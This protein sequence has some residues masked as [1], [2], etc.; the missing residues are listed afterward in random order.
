MESVT[1]LAELFPSTAPSS[2]GTNNANELGQEDFL[3]LMVAQLKNQDP[4]NPQDNSEF[5]AQIAQFGTVSG[6]QDLADKFDGL[7]ATLYSSQALEA[8]GVVGREVVTDSNLGLLQADETINAT[9]N[10][11]TNA[12]GVTL[13]V[14]DTSG[15]LVHTKALGPANKGDLAIQW[16]GVNGEGDTLPPGQYRI[17]VEAVMEGTN[18]AVPVYTHNTV[19]S[20]T[21]G[22]AGQG[23]LLN[24]DGGDQV[25]MSNVRSFL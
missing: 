13:Y 23:V 10:L 1:N 8:A 6:V 12:S 19:E 14:Q 15:K 22:G 3:E 25:S 17:S 5:L 18:Y 9:I 11:P 24:L 16:D 21:L 4:T 7:S 20:V 2:T